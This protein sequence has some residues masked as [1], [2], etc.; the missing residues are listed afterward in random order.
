MRVPDWCRRLARM[1]KGP[2]DSLHRVN[3][4]AEAIENVNRPISCN[5]LTLAPGADRQ[6]PASSEQ[7]SPAF[8][9]TTCPTYR[10][11]ARIVGAG[12]ARNGTPNENAVLPPVGD[13]VGSWQNRRTRIELRAF[14]ALPLTTIRYNFLGFSDTLRIDTWT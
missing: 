10:V 1:R 14:L 8:A 4:E 7:P 3:F 2:V 9:G 13:P 6:T 5:A 11:D 12:L